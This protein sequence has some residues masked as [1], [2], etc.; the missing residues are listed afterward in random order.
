MAVGVS[1]SEGL[2][3]SWSVGMSESCWTVVLSVLGCLD[4]VGL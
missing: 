2:S 4:R 1:V 3:E